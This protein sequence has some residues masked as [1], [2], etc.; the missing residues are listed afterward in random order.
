MNGGSQPWLTDTLARQRGAG[1]LPIL[2]V[3][4]RPPPS[5]AHPAI[6]PSPCRRGPRGVESLSRQSRAKAPEGSQNQ[7]ESTLTLP[8]D[9]PTQKDH[10]KEHTI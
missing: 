5:P 6:R 7:S 1:D 9:S 3:L 4:S 8:S 10:F 2:R